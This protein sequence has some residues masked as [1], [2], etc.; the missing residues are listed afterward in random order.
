MSEYGAGDT[1]G[2]EGGA[3]WLNCFWRARAGRVIV[4]DVFC[5][6]AIECWA[7]TDDEKGS[8]SPK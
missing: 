1:R 2:I 3:M 8:I 6:A 7:G 4:R 5:R